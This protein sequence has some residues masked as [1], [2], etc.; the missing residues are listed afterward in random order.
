M[1]SLCL[2]SRGR[3][4]KRIIGKENNRKREGEI[5]RIRDY[6]NMRLIEYENTIEL[7]FAFT[8]GSGVFSCIGKDFRMGY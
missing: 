2:M 4:L 7:E 3:F 8:T 6:E 5:N 1:R